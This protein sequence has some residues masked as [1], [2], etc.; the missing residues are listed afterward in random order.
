MGGP[1]GGLSLAG[2][3]NAR[4]EKPFMGERRG[5]ETGKKGRKKGLALRPWGRRAFPRAASTIPAGDFKREK[6][7]KIRRVQEI[8]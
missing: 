1:G 4:G 6:N 5:S 3:R 2:P 8:S 7:D